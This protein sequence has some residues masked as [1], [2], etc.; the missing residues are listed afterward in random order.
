M[1]VVALVGLPNCGKSS[2]FNS[3]TKNRQRVANFPGI[4][5]EKKFGQIMINDKQVTIIDLP[6]VYSLDVSSLDEKVTRD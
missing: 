6:G 5:T 2:L 3:I 4:T 1:S